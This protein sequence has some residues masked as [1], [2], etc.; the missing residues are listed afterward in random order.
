MTIYHQK[1]KW[2]V[3]PKK[4]GEY[5]LGTGEVPRGMGKGEMFGEPFPP[6]YPTLCPTHQKGSFIV[7]CGCLGFLTAVIVFSLWM[8]IK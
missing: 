4:T 5:V 6:I 2:F 1:E 8:L 7:G 3:S